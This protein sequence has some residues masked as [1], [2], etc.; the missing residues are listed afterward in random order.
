MNK[1]AHITEYLKEFLK[2]EVSKRGFKKVLVGLSGGLDSA[3]VAVLAQRVFKDELLCVK[4]PSQYSSESSLIDA[5]TL[6]SDFSIRA[7][8]VSIEPLLS[9]YEELNPDMD[10]LRLG[11]FSSRMRMSTIFDISARERALVIGTSNK[12][13]LMLGY[14]TLY[15]D[16]ACAI[17]PIGDLYKSEIFK[18]AK[19]LGISKAIIEKTP[20]ADLWQGQSDEDDLGYTYVE[21]DR[22]LNLLV[23]EKLSKESI[24]KRGIDKEMLEMIIK[25][26]SNNSFKL[27]MPKIA[28]IS[29]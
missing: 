10:R 24:L 25:R 26:V 21:I 23:D 18:L 16:M 4:M 14:G 29:I 12:S 7:I 22:A 3:V 15:G 20:S 13:E 27:E 9:A 8:T 19:Y 28:R 11:N 5:D 17:N 1:Y 6:C 2:A